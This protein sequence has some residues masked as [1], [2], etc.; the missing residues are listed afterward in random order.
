LEYSLVLIIF[1]VLNLMD[2]EPREGV[3]LG[4]GLARTVCKTEV[5]PGE[6]QCPMCLLL[7]EV[8]S[9]SPVFQVGVVGDNLEGL[10]ETLQEVA[11][12]L[13][14]FNDGQHLMVVNL[15]VAFCR[16]HG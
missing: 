15:V 6:V 9:S 8:L 16:E 14:S 1:S 10:R 2:V 12:V 4:I 13:E 7:A 11:P 3:S 5:E